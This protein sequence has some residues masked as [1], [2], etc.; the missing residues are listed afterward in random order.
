LQSIVLVVLDAQ[1][2][3]DNELPHSG[4]AWLSHPDHGE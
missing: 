2:C 1:I 4:N 3:R